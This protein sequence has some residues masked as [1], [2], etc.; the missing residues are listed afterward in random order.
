M[1]F[2]STL[3]VLHSQHVWFAAFRAFPGLCEGALQ[4]AFGCVLWTQRLFLVSGACS[5]LVVSFWSVRHFN[6]SGTDPIDTL[7]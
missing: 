6:A 4:R 2:A 7:I 5:L 1:F 3:P